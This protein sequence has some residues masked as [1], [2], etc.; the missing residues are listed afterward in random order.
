[1]KIIS[2]ATFRTL[3]PAITSALCFLAPAPSVNAEAEAAE[4]TYPY[5]IE[6]EP[7]AIEFAPG[8]RIVITAMRGDRQHLELGGRY[9]LEGSYTLDSAASADLAWFVTSRVPSGGTPIADEEHM[10]ISRGSG[11]FRL[12][13]T[14][15]HDGWL[16]ISFY[17]DGKSHG[18]IY[19]GEK[20]VENT[21]LR[22]KDWS[23]FRAAGVRTGREAAGNGAST[24]PD[25]ANRAIMAYLG[26]PVPPPANLDPKY[27]PTALIGTFT[28]IG[29]QAGWSIEKLAVDDSEFPFL[30]YGL[31]AGKRDYKE[32]EN[33][34]R[35]TKAYEYA[36][37]VVGTTDKEATYFSLNMIPYGQYPPGQFAACNR[38]LMV[39]L[40]M[41]ADRVRQ[42]E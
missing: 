14:V 18:G 28:A 40:Q 34:L 25:D 13:K 21:I 41:L 12:K 22:K 1:M 9:L 33:G 32:I 35:G 7:G 29:K 3:V 38:R 10:N 19:F 8:D 6:V 26:S 42:T 4:T 2:P 15:H 5:V 27:N 11:T 16:H 37:S 23:D 17:V 36:G 20:G 24:I 30:V 31:L 39:R